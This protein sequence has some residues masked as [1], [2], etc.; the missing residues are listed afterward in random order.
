[1]SA[2]FKIIDDEDIKRITRGLD[3]ASQTLKATE[4]RGR[5]RDV[6]E[7]SDQLSLFEA[8]TC[9]SFLA[10]DDLIEQHLEEPL[11]LVQT[12]KRL[13]VA[14]YV[15]AVTSFLFGHNNS[16][17]IW[18]MHTWSKY[19]K[20][21]TKEEFDFAVRDSLLQTL[22]LSSDLIT[23]LTLIQR[24]WCGVRLIIEKLDGDLITHSVRA[25][26][27]D[28]FRLSLEH[29]QYDTPAL[30]FLLQ[31]LQRL[32]EVAPKDYWD[33]M[34]A[35]SPTTVIEQVFNNPQSD[36]FL[37]EATDD[38]SYDTS[39]LKDMLSWIKPFM[40]SLHTAHQAQ[41]CR[42]LTFQLLDRLQTDRFPIFSK[43]ECY[44]IGLGVLNWALA[45]CNKEDTYFKAVGRVVAAETLGVAGTYIKRI[46]AIPSLPATDNFRLELEDSCMRVVKV[47]LAL[48]C[49]YLRTDQEALRQN[50]ELPSGF[51]SYSPAI[52]DA[53]VNH[54]DRG[55]VV[56][57][58]AALTGV[59]GLT[60]IER[61]K[62][63][64]EERYPKEK[65]QFNVTFGHLTHLVCQML[66]RINDF[67][68][69]DLDKLFRHPETA[70]A[71]VASLFSPDASTYEAGVNLIKSISLESARKEAIGHLL[72]HFFETTLNGISWSIRRIAQNRTYA[73]CPRMLKT[74]SDVIDIL[75][76]SQSGLLR[77]RTLSGLSEIHAVENFWQHQWEALRV[78]YEMTEEWSRTRA[79]DASVMKEFCRDIMQ[80]SERFFDQY[81][82]FASA[83]D[84][85]VQIKQEDG[86]TNPDS[87]F[88]SKE[89][90]KH[91][92]R[93]M[94][95]MV[96][97]LRLRDHF[98]AET[99]VKLTKKVLNRLSDR[100]MTLVE[101]SCKFLENVVQGAS[102]GRTV[103]SLQEKA[104]LARA[105]E[106]N[107][108]RPI[109]IIDPETELSDERSREHSGATT[110]AHPSR[111]SISITGKKRSAKSGTIDLV[112][113][114]AKA[115]SS[116]HT[117]EISD[118]DEFGETSEFDKDILDVGRSVELLKR[119]QGERARES[120]KRE[121]HV[122][123]GGKTE[124]QIADERA[125]FR[126]KREKEREAKKKRDAEEILKVKKSK[127]VA[128][129]NL[130][131]SSIGVLG[132]DHPPK[133]SGMMVSSDSESNSGD[134]LDHELFS[135]D[136]KVSKVSDAVKDYYANKLK[137]FKDQGPVKKTRQIRSAK[138]MR[139]RLA[140]DLTSLHRTLLGWDFFHNGESPPG[141]DRDDYSL[142]TNIF[143]NP[144]DYQN[145]FEPLL[146]LE[147]WQGFLK[148]KEEGN[149]R[150]F[151]IKVA[152]RMSVD[153]FIEVSTTMPIGE[154][155]DVGISEAD[156][157][158]MSKGESP[159]TQP[160]Q[161][162]CLARVFKITRK[163]ASMEIA[164]RLNTGN[165][166]LPSVVPN[167]TLHGIKISSITPL[168]R[169]Y[170]ALQGL[171]YFDL[172]D[173]IIKA[174]PSPLLKYTEKQLDSLVT[175]YKINTAQAKAIRSAIDNDAFTLIQGPP[176]SG[177][178][179]TIVA[180]VGA[181]MTGNFG[182]KGVAIARPQT[183]Q[184]TTKA[185]A[186]KKLLVCAPS[187]AAVDELVMRFKQ[188][189]KTLHG[190]FNKL[191]V[192][193]LGRSDAINA[194]V[195][196]VTLEE[197]VNAKLNYATGKKTNAGEDL[198]QIMMAHKSTCEELNALHAKVDE[199][200]ASGKTV[201][202]EQNREFELLKRKKQQL[203]NKIDAVRD[204]GD[205][206]AR[207]A[208]ISRRK[209]QQDILDNAHVICATLSGSGHEMFQN[210][211]IEFET[212][213]IDEA[214]QSIE[215]S[216]LIPLKYG[217]S[218]CIL[219]GDPKQLPPTVLS[220]EAARFQYEQSL[221]VRMQANHPDDVHLLDTQ[222]RMHPEISLFPSKAFYDGKLLNGPDMAQLRVQP[223][224]QSGIL[225]P[226]RFFDVQGTHQSAPRGHSLINIAE[227]NVALKLFDRLV[228]D[229]KGYDFTN[230]IGI[231]TPYKSQLRELRSRFAMS[232]GDSILA[233]VE[234]NTTDAFQGRES[235]IIIFSCVR[236]SMSRTI[237]FL[238]DIRRMNVGI[239]RAK[240]SLW[241][242]GN[243]HSL[244]QGEYWGQ[245]IQD[246]R[247]RNCYTSGDILGLLKQPLLNMSLNSAGKGSLKSAMANTDID[248]WD[249]PI[250]SSFITKHSTVSEISLELSAIGPLKVEAPSGKYKQESRPLVHEPSGGSNGLNP[251]ANC[252]I[253]GN[254]EHMT[255]LCDNV[256]AKLISQDSCFRCG[257][258]DHRKMSCTAEKCLECGGMGHSAKTC[259]STQSISKR[260]KE[261]L[262][263]M[264]ADHKR[265][266][267][268]MPG[269]QAKKQLG[270]HAK[271][272]PTIRTTPDSPPPTG[273]A[274]SK[275]SQ[276][277]AS[278][279][280]REPS[281]PAKAPKG[282]RL[283]NTTGQVSLV[284]YDHSILHR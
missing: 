86:T 88:G 270:D 164:Y 193:R 104:E 263:R 52:W 23:D 38:D 199:L 126:E 12:N 26:D 34:G 236:A 54:L 55:N 138:D 241:V 234:F 174:K 122:V 72:H 190:E 130:A 159:A 212:V 99:S 90:L 8:L 160:K 258:P 116:P 208:E 30:R 92:A 96:K 185:P 226:Y 42:S 32:L 60:G 120:S 261:M 265:A 152:N 62:T 97:W 214:A 27:V 10:R 279:R 102:Q 204:S 69:N 74:S 280:K 24:L 162:H 4:A 176:G 158:L 94:E 247:T 3:N 31:S 177:K 275:E 141:S 136:C 278:K 59:N 35:I 266:L 112:A 205:I 262:G 274:R 229:C 135:N 249:A 166:L 268:R 156:I 13:A 123:K 222:Y 111:N 93:T 231:I 272:V 107:L 9:Q 108:G 255:S 282:P 19:R 153:S 149:F 165:P 14:H 221:F 150:S 233:K 132:K 61:F 133:G 98:L 271:S 182:D 57:A 80:F 192:V 175:N 169:E 264:E 188:G 15:P 22:K 78:I 232:Y 244:M 56:V 168:E 46:L 6:L 201:T 77:T 161:P 51:C 269:I 58:R 223:W 144:L 242:L 178:T 66:E 253:C 219:V 67:D 106:A 189:V 137:Q 134:D 48:E 87:P 25:M 44:R 239:T 83:I 127:A 143:R 40:A 245:M 155:K 187:N 82:I 121:L 95:A 131:L 200:K 139:A 218:K 145:V 100:G 151:A 179:K 71:L 110:P 180:I 195:V 28:L 211:N 181:L 73:S 252:Q 125:S 118:E 115:K 276:S 129:E 68:P 154:G 228:T 2:F 119:Q 146:V 203:S 210:L 237:G 114:T 170:G 240:S 183:A 64:A 267:Q 103:L 209:I 256:D 250:L 184:P 85:T 47:A 167:A 70:V 259:T 148:S 17:C 39:S 91:P 117:I 194:K 53:V 213:I 109:T 147:A 172:C 196:D 227:I 89:L 50:K 76:D 206:V 41:A 142:V 128:Q 251:N 163:K 198:Q 113:W 79:T 217:C 224:H 254:F 63:G 202:P 157:V 257:S 171:K 283:S 140:P 215:L 81:S 173:E 281:P 101:T 45:N 75:C 235:E 33:A 84:S 230:K 243:A 65:S 207:D 248:M 186:T 246:A 260:A 1:M 197:L 225:G 36:R 273:D 49:K 284:S 220:R 5:G 105:L 191:S 37:Q 18:A 124:A 216:A 43:I 16:R 238:S 20:P 277:H 7:L 29:L 21:L 11:A